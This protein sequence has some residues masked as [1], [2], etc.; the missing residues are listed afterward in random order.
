MMRD[1]AN[2]TAGLRG[3]RGMQIAQLLH[4]TAHHATTR[5]EPMTSHSAS[6]TDKPIL[7][8]EDDPDDAELTIRSLRRAGIRSP[9]ITAASP[10]KALA[11]LRHLPVHSDQA[12][13]LLSLVLLDLNLPGTGGLPLLNAIRS[14][15][16]ASR[17]PVV[18]L[19]G[20]VNPK[21][22]TMCCANG[23]LGL[24]EKP[25]DAGELLQLLSETAEARQAA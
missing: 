9:V 2:D 14:D 1:T 3:A 20:S 11:L 10:A 13:P 15:P 18:V 19:T 23:A 21:D 25:I 5:S 7:L 4:R 22:R 24:I 6:L 8:V 16:H 12:A 17:V